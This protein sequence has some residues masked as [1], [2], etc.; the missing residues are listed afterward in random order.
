M[1][2]LLS[3]RAPWRQTVHAGVGQGLSHLPR[4]ALGDGHRV[5]SGAQRGV[6]LIR[7]IGDG[8]EFVD[9]R[10]VLANPPRLPKERG[11]ATIA[12]R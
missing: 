11:G 10:G 12:T 3:K 5:Q 7:L 6:L 2:D 4:A 9:G 8:V 1:V